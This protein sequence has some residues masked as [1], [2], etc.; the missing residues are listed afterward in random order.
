MNEDTECLDAIF[1][2]RK[3]IRIDGEILTMSTSRPVLKLLLDNCVYDSEAFMDAVKASCR[4]DGGTSVALDYLRPDMSDPHNRIAAAYATCVKDD[5]DLLEGAAGADLSKE[6]LDE[7]LELA[8]ECRSNNV[9][10]KLLGFS[11]TLNGGHGAVVCR[12]VEKRDLAAVTMLMERLA[13]SVLNEADL[14]RCFR[15]LVKNEA[16]TEE[17]QEDSDEEWK[18]GM[19]DS[20]CDDDDDDDT[21]DD[22]DDD[23]DDDDDDDDDNDD[24][25]DDD[26]DRDCDD[27]DDDYGDD[28]D[29]EEEEED[30][31]VEVREGTVARK[32]KESGEKNSQDAEKKRMGESDK[33]T[34]E[35]RIAELIISHSAARRKEDFETLMETL[36]CKEETTRIERL[37]YLAFP[38]WKREGNNPY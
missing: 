12:A 33:E 14:K 31:E 15:C 1:R 11:G 20:D 21:D 22:D 30:H 35:V 19:K 37:A 29:E 32:G 3:E 24:D 5:P 7:C 34:T 9:L 16:G 13:P 27:D 10:G 6:E 2:H 17:D 8:T 38:N 4:S 26:D 25:D 36:G 18:E 23:R 28:D